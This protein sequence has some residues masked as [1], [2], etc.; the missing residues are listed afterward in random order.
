VTIADLPFAEGAPVDVLRLDREDP[1]FTG[2][3][4]CRLDSVWLDSRE[5]EPSVRVT[6]ALVLALH[7][8]EEPEP[9]DEDIE[10]EFHDQGVSVL[11]SRFLG[12]WLPRVL[13]G[14]RAIVLALCNPRGG[15]V[16]TPAAAGQTPIH[17]GL[18]DVQSWLEEDE[19]GRRIRLLADVWRTAV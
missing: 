2:A 9:L 7:S 10:L 16:S 19:T 11:L 1:D 4:Y 6:D 13:G 17:Y 18:G 8:P 14:E 5:G 15:K 3:G 12:V